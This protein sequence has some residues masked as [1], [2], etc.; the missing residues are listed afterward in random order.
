MKK[1]SFSS[2]LWAIIVGNRGDEFVSYTEKLLNSSGIE[3]IICEDIYS[4]VCKLT[5]SRGKD[6]HVI[7]RIEHLSVEKG[8]FFDKA[9]ENNVSCYCL[10]NKISQGQQ[11]LMAKE[12]G[13]FVVKG[14]EQ[15][16]EVVTEMVGDEQDSKIKRSTTFDKDEF[17][18]TQ[19]ELDALLGI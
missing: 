6:I 15:L 3:A 17:A 12:K 5:I 13:A 10:V 4:A 1:N 8:R 19:A 18:M 9:Q 11:V 16:K 14:P 2:P 7:G